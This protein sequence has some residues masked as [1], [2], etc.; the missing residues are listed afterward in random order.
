[1]WFYLALFTSFLSSLK[2]IIDKKILVNVNPSLMFWSALT[3]ST[4]FI[5]TAA[6]IEGIPDVNL[7]FFLGV[8]GSDVVYSISKILQ[9][10]VIKSSNLSAVYPLV[11]L[12]PIITLIIAFFPPLNETPSKIS[13]IGVVVTLLG[14]YILNITKS[15]ENILEPIKQLF[16]NKASLWMIVSIVIDSF[17]SVFDKFAIN[18]TFPKNSSFVLMSENLIII[19]GIL[20]LLLWRNKSFKKQI[21]TNFRNLFIQG[22]IVALSTIIGM[23]VIGNGNIGVVQTIFKSQILLVILFSYFFFKDKPKKETIIGSI[24]M[25]MGVVIIKLGL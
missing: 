22:L 3:I 14:T 13:L 6:I 25:I 16:V 9:F 4:P 12:G 17:V 7:Y 15:K 23:K 24:I 2:T 19:F 20:P 18:N 8:V 11:S 10:R 1:M 5:S 21:S